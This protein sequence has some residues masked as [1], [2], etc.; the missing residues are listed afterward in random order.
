MNRF[1]L[2]ILSHLWNE[3]RIQD[4]KIKKYFSDL[5]S[6]SKLLYLIMAKRKTGSITNYIQLRKRRFDFFK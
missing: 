6:I 2:I 3:A 5:L 1:N 4:S